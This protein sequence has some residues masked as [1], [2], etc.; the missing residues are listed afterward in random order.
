MHYH[1]ESLNSSGK[2]FKAHGKTVKRHYTTSNCLEK[3]QYTGFI[4]ILR[5]N[6]IS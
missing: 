1:F 6:G 5:A 3:I 4:K 2:S